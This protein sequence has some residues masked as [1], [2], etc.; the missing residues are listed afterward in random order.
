MH[1]ELFPGEELFPRLAR[2]VCRAGVLP[3]K[4]L[5]EAW[6]VARR[7]RRRLKGGRVVD[8]AAGHGLLAWTMLL[9]D[10]RSPSA[11]AFDPTIPPSAARLAEVLVERWPRLAGRVSFVTAPPALGADDMV[12]SCHACGGLTDD[13]IHAAMAARA[14]VAVLPCCHSTAKNDDGGLSGWMDNALAID[15]ARALKLRH[16]GYRVWTSMIPADITPK[17]RLL[18]AWP[19]PR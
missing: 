4:E 1:A 8:W 19:E 5:H 2:A 3:R 13:A 14:S 18:V 11:V 7:C 12:V 10:D 6:E 9:I 16:A 17:N 15:A